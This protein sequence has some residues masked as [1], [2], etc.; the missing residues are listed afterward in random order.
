MEKDDH[1]TVVEFIHEK[2]VDLVPIS[3]LVFDEVSL[4]IFF[5]LHVGY[6]PRL[7]KLTRKSLN[8]DNSFQKCCFLT[9]SIIVI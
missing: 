3:W 7:N 9:Y 8:S 2:A 1:Y 4:L 5:A 6:G